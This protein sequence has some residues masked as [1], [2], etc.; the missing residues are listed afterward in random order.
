MWMTIHKG[1]WPLEK[2]MC[3]V[4]TKTFL[5]CNLNALCKIWMDEYK[6]M[7]ENMLRSQ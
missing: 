6:H 5:F 3:Q 2:P 7:G 1:E 4:K